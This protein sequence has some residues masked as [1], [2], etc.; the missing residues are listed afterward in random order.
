[1]L[2]VRWI[3]LIGFISPMG[4]WL[5]PSTAL[6]RDLDRR[7][8]NS[9][10]KPWFDQLKSRN[11]PAVRMPTATSSETPSSWRRVHILLLSGNLGPTVQKCR[12]NEAPH[13]ASTN[14]GRGTLRSFDAVGKAGQDS[15]QTIS[16]PAKSPK[17]GKSQLDPPSYF[18]QRVARNPEPIDRVN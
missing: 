14:G 4:L 1:V 2:V 10:L 11:G 16:L 6:G 7:Y 17:R 9:P 3:P 15:R 18:D 5:M 12:V 13:R 8:T